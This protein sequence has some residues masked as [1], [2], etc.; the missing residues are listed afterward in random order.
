[1]LRKLI[2]T[3][4]SLAGFVLR[5]MLGIVFFPHG[6][7]KM[8]GWY[9]GQGLQTTIAG[10]GS[11][12]IPAF[13][14]YLVVFAEFFGSLGLV[15][16]LLTRIAALGIAVIMAVAIFMVHIRFGFFMNWVGNQPGEGFEYH[17]LAIAIAVA[18]LIRGGERWSIDGW[19]AR[20]S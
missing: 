6:A 10:F 15:L 11:Q 20:R 8:L 14:A 2:E 3:D 16:G 5:I 1:M 4:D 19:L 18:L 12:G 7:Q 17:L 9:G 13:L